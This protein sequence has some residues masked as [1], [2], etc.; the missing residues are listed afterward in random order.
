MASSTGSTWATAQADFLGDFYCVDVV[1]PKLFSGNGP[2]HGRRKLLI[3]LFLGP[4]GVQDKGAPLLD[5]FQDVIE[6][7]II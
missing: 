7:N 3:H 4:V 2:A 6:M 5:S 1:E